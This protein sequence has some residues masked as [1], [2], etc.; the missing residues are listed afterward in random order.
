MEQIRSYLAIEQA[1]FGERIATDI[2]LSP[3][4]RDWPIPP[5]ILQ[6]LVENSVKHGLLAREGPGLVRLVARRENGCLAVLVEDDGVGMDAATIRRIPS[7]GEVEALGG[8]IGAR[9]CNHRLTHLYGPAYGLRIRSRPGGGSRVSLRIPG[10]DPAGA[11]AS[12][13]GGPCG[14]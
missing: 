9:N 7:P 11:P 5:L 10:R 4:C 13:V 3:E 8:G 12:G 1:R 14:A 2:D 6:P